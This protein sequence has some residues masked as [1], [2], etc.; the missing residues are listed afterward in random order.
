MTKNKTHWMVV[1]FEDRAVTTYTTLSELENHLD[2][3]AN[4]AM[5]FD[6]G[7]NSDDIGVKVYKILP[8]SGPKMVEVNLE[9]ATTWKIT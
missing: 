9:I 4:Q 1:D 8:A 2:T 5:L 7:T 3:L 6:S